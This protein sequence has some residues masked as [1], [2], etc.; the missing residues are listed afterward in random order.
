MKI[1]DEAIE[2]HNNIIVSRDNVMN[3]CGDNNVFGLN[4]KRPEDYYNVFEQTKKSNA[5]KLADAKQYLAT[6][7]KSLYYVP[8][9]K[10]HPKGIFMVG[11]REEIGRASCRERV[12]SPV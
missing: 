3:N 12:S 6:Q 7:R 5:E 8:F 9:A 2:I 10:S 4:N 11:V 1:K